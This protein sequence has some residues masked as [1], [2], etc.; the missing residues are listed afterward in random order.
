MSALSSTHMFLPIAFSKGNGLPVASSTVW[1]P[2]W[3][4]YLVAWPSKSF[5]FGVGSGIRVSPSWQLHFYLAKMVD[6]N[7]HHSSKDS[8]KMTT[9]ACEKVTTFTTF[10]WKVRLSC[11]YCS[12]AKSCPTFLQPLGLQHARLLCPWLSL[13]ASSNSC[14]LNQWCH[15]II[16]SSITPFFCP[17]SL[18]ASGS[19]SMSWLF[20]SG[21]LSIGASASASV[22]L[23]SIQGW[24]PVRLIGLISL[25]SK[26]LS[27]VFSNTIVWKH[28]FFG[29]LHSWWSISH[30]CTWLLE[31]Q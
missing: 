25:L 5:F 18:P 29:A 8:F 15:P 27:R 19:F 2:S 20:T 1:K 23:M 14:S 12:V 26:E 3:K 22:L 10:L 11:W 16:S 24:F 28:Q 13:R 17:Q 7:T 6:H 21:G 4:G 9:E 30:I 31:R